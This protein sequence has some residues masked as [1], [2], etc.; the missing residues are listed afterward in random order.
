[1]VFLVRATFV[2]T[3]VSIPFVVDFFSRFL[4]FVGNRIEEDGGVGGGRYG[5]AMSGAAAS[6]LEAGRVVDSVGRG[7]DEEE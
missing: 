6:E 4:G 7:A 5:R 3:E 1:M 2:S